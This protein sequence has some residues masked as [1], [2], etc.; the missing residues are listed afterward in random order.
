MKN[1][2]ILLLGVYASLSGLSWSHWQGNA[3]HT[4]NLQLP[5]ISSPIQQWAKTGGSFTTIDGVIIYNMPSHASNMHTYD[6]FGNS[7]WNQALPDKEYY[8]LIS[9]DRYAFIDYSEWTRYGIKYFRYYFRV[10]DK[11]HNEL[12]SCQASGDFMNNAGRTYQDAIKGNNTWILGTNYWY[13][14]YYFYGTLYVFNSSGTEQFHLDV[15]PSFSRNSLAIDRNN[16]VIYIAGEKGYYMAD[17]YPAAVVAVNMNGTQKWKRDFSSPTASFKHSPII[18]D[19]TSNLHLYATFDTT[20]YCINGSDGSISWQK[21]GAT[22]A[23]AVDMNNNGLVFSPSRT[24]LSQYSSSGN[25]N[26]SYTFPS[27]IKSPP[28]IDTTGNVYIACNQ[29]LYSLTN[30]LSLRWQLDVSNINSEV[31]LLLGD[32]MYI[33]VNNKTAGTLTCISDRTSVKRFLVDIPEKES[34]FSC[35]PNPFRERLFVKSESRIEIYTI[36]GRLMMIKEK[37]N[38]IIDTKDFAKGIYLIKS[39]KKT[40]TVVKIED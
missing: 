21:E 39:G 35:Y 16:S 8:S 10:F 2:I 27:E 4:G 25:L 23:P 12:W 30:N 6:Y 40:R 22:N 11:Q 24:K 14:G 29:R 7:T 28:I 26:C 19:L 18:E 20:L 34:L 31:N 3:Q 32:Y 15:N 17:E 36:E 13:E 38:Q 9:D 1:I 5:S 33:F 37:G